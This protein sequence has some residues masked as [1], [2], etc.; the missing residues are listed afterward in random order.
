MPCL[1]SSFS[2]NCNF[3]KF[4]KVPSYPL[5]SSPWLATYFQTLSP[6]LSVSTQRAII[7]GDVTSG[8]ISYSNSFHQ[9]TLIFRPYP[10]CHPTH[11]RSGSALNVPKLP[12][13]FP[14]LPHLVLFARFG[15]KTYP[16]LTSPKLTLSRLVQPL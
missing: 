9:D 15:S 6:S 7:L 3:K 1:V 12:R 16:C 8:S 4:R 14:R 10:V 13:L 5:L 2:K 11:P